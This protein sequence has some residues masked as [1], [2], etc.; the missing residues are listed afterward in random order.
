MTVLAPIRRT[1]RSVTDCPNGVGHGVG[2]AH[3]GEILQGRFDDDG[4]LTHGTVTLPYPRK[5]STA[6]FRAHA[7][8]AL[9]VVPH[10][11]SKA[12]R[13]AG[14]SLRSLGVT[15]G[16]VLE[17]S[18]TIPTGRGCGSSTA[19]VVASI[20]AVADSF[21]TTLSAAR[22]AQLAVRAEGASDAI[23]FGDRVVLFASRD[24][25]VIEDLVLAVPRLE[26]LAVDLDVSGVDTLAVPSPVYGRLEL[27]TFGA[28]RGLLRRALIDRSAT[29]LAR[30]AS[31]SAE[32]NQRHLPNP[33]YDL[34]VDVQR[35]VGAIGVQVAHTGTV[36]SLLFDPTDPDT[37][38]REAMAIRLLDAAGIHRHWHY[39][40]G[41]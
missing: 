35:R 13:A 22:T 10:W 37:V 33:L 12:R 18:T 27:S 19:D 6:R 21:G 31:V 39:Q 1:S 34:M 38:L 15:A 4:R 24:G 2:I 11:R 8:E 5:S 14:E 3:L 30:V 20:R 28:L 16:G 17:V 36:M 29:L 23:M 25:H 41:S 32:I 26:V 7:E 40:V 9:V